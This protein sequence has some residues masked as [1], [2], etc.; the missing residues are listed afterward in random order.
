MPFDGMTRHKGSLP[1]SL[2]KSE[3]KHQDD[4]RECRGMFALVQ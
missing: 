2:N 1:S 4:S 3:R